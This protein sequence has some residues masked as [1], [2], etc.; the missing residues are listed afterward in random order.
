MEPKFPQLR[1]HPHLPPLSR[2]SRRGGTSA[3]MLRCAHA[4]D[5]GFQ[6]RQVPVDLQ[7]G[8]AYVAAWPSW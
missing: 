6:W 8:L 1:Q 7:Y 5:A 4:R 2:A 3:I